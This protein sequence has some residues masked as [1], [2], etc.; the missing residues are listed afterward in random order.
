[1]ITHFPYDYEDRSILKKY[2]SLPRERAVP[3][4]A[5]LCQ[6]SRKKNK[7]GIDSVSGIYKDDTGTIIA[8]WYNQ[9]YIKKVLTV[10]ES[11][12]FYGKIVRGYKTLEV[13][14]PVYEKACKEEHKN[15]MKIVPFTMQRRILHKTPSEP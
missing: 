1:L 12:I 9:P 10:G 13:Q 4:R 7:A 8:T 5:L 11:Y 3:L 6:R 14:N 2:V 15:T